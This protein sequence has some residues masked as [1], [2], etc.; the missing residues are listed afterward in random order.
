MIISEYSEGCMF[1]GDIEIEEETSFV[2][3]IFKDSMVCIEMCKHKGK[4]KKPNIELNQKG[5]IFNIIT[6]IAIMGIG[7]VVSLASPSAGGA[8]IAIGGGL[9]ANG[10]SGEVNSSCENKENKPKEENSSPVQIGLG[11]I[12]V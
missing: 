6:G 3:N 10:I 2:S 12:S 5:N 9:V 7:A 4:G 11:G 1:A 8:L